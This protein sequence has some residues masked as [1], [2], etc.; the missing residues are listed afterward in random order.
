MKKL[1]KVMSFCLVASMLVVTG[2]EKSENK[3]QVNETIEQLNEAP[4]VTEKEA[5][6]IVR[7]NVDA[8][9]NAFNEMEK[10]NGWSRNNPGDLGTAKKGVKGLV[11]DKFVEKELPGLLDTFNRSRET[12]ML[13]FPIHIEPDVRITYSQKNDVLK[14]ETLTLAN[15]MGNEAEMWEFVLV[16]TDGNWLMDKWSSNTP[17]DL[18]LTKE[19]AKELLRVQGFKNVSFVRE[20]NS[21][22]KK[23]I[24]KESNGVVAVDAKNS[25][26]THNVDDEEQ[27][28]VTKKDF[29]QEQETVKGNDSSTY[30]SSKKETS[31]AVGKT[32]VLNELAALENQEKHINAISTNDI[33]NEIEG[34][35]EL[36]DNKLNEIYS[37]LKNTMSPDAFQSLKTKQIAWV[38]EKESKV[39]AIGT[40]TNNGTMRRIEASEEKYN[41]TKERCY[42]LVNGY[43]N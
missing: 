29:I 33:V 5:K 37:T 21:G 16:Y 28:K 10:E 39:K 8:I 7:K 31:L 23:Y 34:N 40:D 38:K 36:W 15:D 27:E 17:V 4:E 9:A 2:C 3:V 35:Y 20:E 24:F 25:V 6:K 19:E 30:T 22:N 12:D 11:S 26:I 32:K 14:V 43:M 13:P 41:M 42:E 18:N 1:S